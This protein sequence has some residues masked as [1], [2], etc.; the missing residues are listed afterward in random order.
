MLPSTQP[1]IHAIHGF[2]GAGKTTFARQLETQ[3]P[4]LRLNSDEWMVQLYG[5]DP[6]EEVFRPGIVRVN[7]L[8]RQLAERALALGLHVVLDDGF[9]TRASRDDLRRWAADLGVPLR[10]YALILPE[11]EARRRVRERNAQLG[12]L[13]IAPETYDLFWQGFE[14]LQQGEPHESVP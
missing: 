5:P 7:V 4:A 11:A 13:Y 8:M 1:T 3:L 12:S 2:I 14:P 6:P 10:L 9:W